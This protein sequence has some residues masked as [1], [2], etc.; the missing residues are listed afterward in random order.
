MREEGKGDEIEESVIRK[1]GERKRGEQSTVKRKNRRN[2]K[3]K[4]RKRRKRVTR[5][6]RSKLERRVAQGNV[7][8]WAE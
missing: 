6:G 3:R 7:T 8:T 2:G 4:R 5:E 1:G